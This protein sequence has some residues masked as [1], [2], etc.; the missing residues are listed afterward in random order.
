MMIEDQLPAQG[1]KYFRNTLS[2]SESMSTCPAGPQF[3]SIL[4]GI[5]ALCV[6]GYLTIIGALQDSKPGG[7]HK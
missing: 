5:Q 1:L 3:F 7:E 2:G 6:G 4:T